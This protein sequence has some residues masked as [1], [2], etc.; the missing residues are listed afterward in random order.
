ML[1][2]MLRVEVK[3]HNDGDENNDDKS[4]AIGLMGL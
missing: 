2:V 4:D 1:Q 3:R